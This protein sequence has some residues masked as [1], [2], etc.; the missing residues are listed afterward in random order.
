MIFMKQ[1]LFIMRNRKDSIFIPLN[2]KMHKP[3]K[4]AESVQIVVF[5]DVTPRN[6]E[7]GYRSFAGTSSG[8]KCIGYML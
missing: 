4:H 2:E 7:G 5:W 1:S 8:L 6:I 3:T